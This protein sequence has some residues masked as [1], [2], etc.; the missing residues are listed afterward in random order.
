MA[1]NG[2]R[3]VT[4]GSKPIDGG[5]LIFDAT[6]RQMLLYENPETETFLRP[7][8]GSKEFINGGGRW[9]L[10]LQDAPPSMIRDVSIIR[11]RLSQVRQYRLGKIPQRGKLD[12]KQEAGTSALTLAE[13][14][15]SFHVT[16]IPSR[17]FLVIPEVSSEARP[18]IPIGWAELPTI[19]SNKLRLLPD[20]S[21]WEF[22][23]LTSRIHM[24]W[25]DHIGGRLKSDYQYGIGLNYNT[26]P[27][28]DATPPQRA[29]VEVLAQ[30][31]LD[32]RA[33]PKNATS[34]LAD[35]YDPDRMPGELFRAH[36]ALDAAV[37]RLYAA[38]GFADDRARVEH[39]FRLYEALV[40]PTT[41]AP[42][43]NQRTSRRV[44]RRVSGPS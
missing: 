29:K 25:T 28:P 6:E 34:T 17:P 43:A 38:K 9:I 40:M 22:S 41:A 32:A 42:A 3:R 21:L 1:L 37:D 4:I 19:P 27:W 31:V 15:T 23:I 35:L 16:V 7:Y 18:Y 44:A 14:P 24:A 33:L 36:K 39:L 20:A 5:Y 10:A 2:A 11:E 8:V 30:A 13:T 12:R 26:F